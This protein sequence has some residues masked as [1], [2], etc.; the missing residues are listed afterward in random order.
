M[1]YVIIIPP[2]GY[3]SI[4]PETDGGRGFFIPYALVGIPLTLVFLGFL[5]QILN[6]GVD[7]ATKCLGR[8]VTFDWAQL[9][10]ISAVGLVGFILIPA[11][12]FA[13]IDGWTYFE[14]IYFTFVSLTTVGFGD[15]VPTTPGTF[16]GLYRFSLICWLFF[17]LAFIALI[18]AQTQERIENVRE[19]VKKCRKCIKRTGGEL[20]LRKKN[21]DS[22]DSEKGE[23][24]EGEKE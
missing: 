20:G 11:I 22:D 18:I 24:T 6:K 17:G 16:S 3:G 8:R 7:R 9:L 14:A 5:G 12:I 4:A 23:E 10:I 1:L 19:N 21:K 2:I 15:F 13:V